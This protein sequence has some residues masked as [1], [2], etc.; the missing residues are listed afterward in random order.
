MIVH[1][2][3]SLQR[4]GKERQLATIYKYSNKRIYPLKIICFNEGKNTYVSEYNM[5]ADCIFLKSRGFFPR[6][7]ELRSILQGFSPDL[8]YAWGGMESLF[9]WILSR[10]LGCPFINGS[11]RHGIVLFKFS[12]IFRFLML[13]LSKYIVANSRAGLRANRL[14][15]GYVLYN[16]IDKSLYED[17]S[18][19]EKNIFKKDVLNLNPYFPIIVSVANLVP[20]K[21]YFTVIKALKVVKER[22]HNFYYLIIGDGQLKSDISAN[23]VEHGLE[24]NVKLLGCVTNVAEYLRI[25]EIFLH[26]SRGEGCSNAILEAMLNALPII[27]SNTGGTPEIVS[28]A[29]GYLFKYKD[30]EDLMQ[31]IMYLIENPEDRRRMGRR[32]EEMASAGFTAEKMISEYHRILGEVFSQITSNRAV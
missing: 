24:A 19:E 16:G 26:S 9:A 10:K 2:I 30:T 29:N 28:E 31:K 5:S 8:L 4:G 22:G 18:E 3:S 20:Y 13:H 1:L 23:I 15:R 12:H 11:V 14:K 7:K 17:V 21:D 27:A 6:L 25:A 32:S